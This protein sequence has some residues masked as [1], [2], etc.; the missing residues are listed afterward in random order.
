[1]GVYFLSPPAKEATPVV[2]SILISCISQQIPSEYEYAHWFPASPRTCRPR[3][4]PFHVL[5]ERRAG[6]GAAIESKNGNVVIAVNE[7]GKQIGY[8][9]GDVVRYFD[10]MDKNILG[11]RNACPATPSGGKLVTSNR[12]A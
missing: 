2:A 12:L 1:M 8:R 3:P 7:Q 6:N 10:D 9:I 4:L 11:K 5:Q